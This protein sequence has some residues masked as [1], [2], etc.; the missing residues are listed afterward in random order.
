MI[1]SV[2]IVLGIIVILLVSTAVLGG[3]AFTKRTRND[4]KELFKESDMT[5]P[6]VI[7]EE[8]VQ[9]L[10]EPV[11]RYLRYTQIIGTEEINTVRLKQDGY[12]RMKEDQKW[13]PL[14]AE[15][16]FRVDSAEFIWIAK[17]RA[18]P[19]LSI[20]AKDEFV[21]GRGNLVVKLLGLITVVDA[22]GNA[23]DHGELLRFLA[24]CIWFPSAF[25]NDYITWESIDNTSAKATITYNGVSASAVFH[26]NEKGE[27]TRITAKRYMEVNGEFVLEDW[28]GQIVEYKMFNGVI[29]PSKVNIIWKLKTGDFCYDQIEI[30]DI[31]YNGLSIY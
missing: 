1:K 13:M 4:A 3:V 22:K 25:L 30:V 5:K 11:Q 20:H 28:E 8:D 12:F 9:D 10:P 21:E 7:T 24:E 17:V 2:L 14:T 6:K 27:V 19:L 26:F 31:E 23:V 15:Q 16:Y 18:A 29:V